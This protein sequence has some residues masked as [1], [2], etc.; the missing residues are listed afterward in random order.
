MIVWNGRIGHHYGYSSNQV[1]LGTILYPSEKDMHFITRQEVSG[2]INNF[3]LHQV[4]WSPV[5]SVMSNIL[6]SGAGAPG[7]WD[8]SPGTYG[9][10]S[11]AATQQRY[12]RR[13]GDILNDL[14]DI[15]AQLNNRR[16][17]TRYDVLFEATRLLGV[18]AEENAS[19]RHLLSPTAGS[20][21]NSMDSPAPSAH[22]VPAYGLQESRPATYNS[23]L[24]NNTQIS[25]IDEFMTT[26]SMPEVDELMRITEDMPRYNN[27]H[28]SNRYYQN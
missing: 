4:L 21:E 6:S 25:A 28:S 8:Q 11:K 19:L 22:T 9:R 26:G 24:T 27:T 12:R 15:I 14:R 13:E 10:Q 5:Y 17:Q 1:D 20:G 16:P 23:T 7:D 2:G 3:P 18:L